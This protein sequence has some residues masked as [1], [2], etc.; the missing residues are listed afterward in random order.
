MAFVLEKMTTRRSF[1]STMTNSG[2]SGVSKNTK[3]MRLR[4]RLRIKHA[5]LWVQ[6]STCS[7]NGHEISRIKDWCIRKRIRIKRS[8]T[9]EGMARRIIAVKMRS[10]KERAERTLRVLRTSRKRG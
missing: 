4:R 9:R 2:C 1:I 5:F 6:N 8:K 10:S 7:L 3:K